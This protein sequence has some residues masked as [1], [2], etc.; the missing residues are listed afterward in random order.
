MQTV[1]QSY[2]E[3]ISSNK[4]NESNISEIRLPFFFGRKL[5][6]G[7]SNNSKAATIKS[8]I[9]F[10]KIESKLPQNFGDSSTKKMIALQI[11]KEENN[12]KIGFLQRRQTIKKIGSYGQ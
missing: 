9:F 2:S 1:N 3:I 8:K 5:V 4:E 12:I 11:I 10:I 6:L 7:I